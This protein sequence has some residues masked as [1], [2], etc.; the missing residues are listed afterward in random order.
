MEREKIDIALILHES[1]DDQDM[2]L[3][4]KRVSIQ[5]VS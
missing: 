2:D 5:I 4:K 1:L 3:K